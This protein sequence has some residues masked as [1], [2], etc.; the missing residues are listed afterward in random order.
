MY[1][2][3]YNSVEEYKAEEERLAL[4]K[5]IRINRR[6]KIY[7]H[8]MKIAL[9]MYAITFSF[10]LIF[11]ILINFT[12][13]KTLSAIFIVAFI[14]SLI[15]TSIYAGF[16]IRCPHCDYRRKGFIWY[17][18]CPECGETLECSEYIDKIDMEMQ[19]KGEGVPYSWEKIDD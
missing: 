19:E 14:I 15:V 1:N 17:K 10:F 2:D 5:N 12:A 3:R 7:R 11:M 4:E 13:L 18:N 16:N 9:I 6:N 8:D